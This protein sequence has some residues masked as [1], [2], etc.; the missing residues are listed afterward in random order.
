MTTCDPP[1]GLG[2]RGCALW[3]SIVDAGEFGAAE[4]VLAVEL[5]RTVDELERLAV[6]LAGTATLVAVG[7]MGQPRPHPLLDEVR[8]HRQAAAALVEALGLGELAAAVVAS[9][10]GVW[11]LPIVPMRR[12]R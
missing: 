11:E 5:C 10:E 9:D 8:R 2:D 12:S 3:A 6:E 7:S 1:P 4:T